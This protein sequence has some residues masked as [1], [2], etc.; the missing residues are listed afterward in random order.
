MKTKKTSWR[1]GF[2]LGQIMATLLVVLP[3]MAFSIMFLLSYWNVMQ[4]DYKLKLIAN[5]AA[6]YAN[7]SQ[8]PQA[9][10][11]VLAGSSFQTRASR[12]CPGGLS[13]TAGDVGDATVA[14]NISIRVLYTTPKT[15]IYLSEQNVSTRIE[16]YSY[17]EQNMSVLLTCPTI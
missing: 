1:K 10:F 3:T 8:D 16:T 6:D 4:V 9:D 2:G 7:S 14:E 17:H 15:D 11:S 5:M 12:L 13:I